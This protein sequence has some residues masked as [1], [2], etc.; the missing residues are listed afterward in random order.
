M[1]YFWL[2]IFLVTVNTGF[3]NFICRPDKVFDTHLKSVQIR[4]SGAELSDPT[5]KLGSGEML[6]ITFDDLLETQRLFKYKVIHCDA[7]WVPDNLPNSF[8]IEGSDE[9][10]IELTG[11]SFNTL[12]FYKHYEF[13]FPNSEISVKISGN[14][15]IQVYDRYDYDFENMLCQLSFSVYEPLAQ[16]KIGVEKTPISSYGECYQELSMSL[17]YNQLK[18]INPQQEIKIKVEQNNCRLD[19][20]SPVPVFITS[21]GVDYKRLGNNRYPVGGEYR[22]F[23]IRNLRHKTQRVRQILHRDKQ[24]QVF[25]EEDKPY[26][27]Y[28]YY[29]DINGKYVIQQT[30]YDNSSQEEG[31]YANVHFTLQTLEPFNGTVYIFGELTGWSLRNEYALPYNELRGTYEIALLLKQGLYNYTYVLISDDGK[32]VWNGIDKCSQESENQYGV[33]TYYKSATDRYDKLVA[34]GWIKS[35]Q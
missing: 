11:E 18:V 12:T 15:L 14:Y 1:K 17:A 7:D 3:G 9:G 35:R 21:D 27:Q 24:W 31:D 8:Y 25:V 13:Q 33:Y 2:I 19:N 16:L 20:A 22:T 23:D 5:I 32:I 26:Q 28:I 6:Q 4:R 29:P 30:D 10:Y 34:V